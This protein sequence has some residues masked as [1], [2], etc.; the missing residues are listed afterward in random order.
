MR[1]IVRKNYAPASS[2]GKGPWSV[3]PRR[4]K[5]IKLVSGAMALR[6]VGSDRALLL[7]R[8]INQTTNSNNTTT[9]QTANTAQSVVRKKT[10]GIMQTCY[11]KTKHQK[12]NIK[13]NFS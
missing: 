5:I 2:R 8:V 9:Q 4:F 11:D 13:R 7:T 3:L 12:R 6:E 1:G 10:P